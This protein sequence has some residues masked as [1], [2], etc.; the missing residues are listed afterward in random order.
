MSLVEPTGQD[1]WRLVGSF[2]PRDHL[3][4]ALR[5]LCLV[6]MTIDHLSQHSL[7]RFTYESFGFV[8]AAVGF[9]FLSGLVAGKVFGS[10]QITQG[11]CAVRKRAWHRARAIYFAEVFLLTILVIVVF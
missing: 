2:I 9:I 11:S 8:N 4:D 10:V 7:R 3:L 5:G 1:R 6:I